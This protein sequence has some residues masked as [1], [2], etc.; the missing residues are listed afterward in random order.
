GDPEGGVDFPPVLRIAARHGYEG[1]L[2]I[3]AEQDP[4]VRD[5]V[6]Y[7]SMGLKA[8]RQMARAAGLDPQPAGT[9]P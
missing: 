4:A 9:P 5:P 2:V 6:K 7:Q 3:E 1:W 8:L